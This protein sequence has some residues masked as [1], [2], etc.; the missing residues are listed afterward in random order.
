MK[1]TE[2]SKKNTKDTINGYVYDEKNIIYF[3]IIYGM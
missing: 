3:K 1:M 2:N